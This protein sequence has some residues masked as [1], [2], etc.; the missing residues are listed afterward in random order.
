[1]SSHVSTSEDCVAAIRTVNWEAL[2]L[3][4][5]VVGHII[6]GG[7]IVA[8]VLTAER[9]LWTDLSLVV[10][11]VLSLHTITTLVR[12]IKFD[13]LTSIK[14]LPWLWSLIEVPIKFT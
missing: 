2:A 4:P 3:R 7:L 6:I 10:S 13:K 8:A 9:A 12:T 1:M 11:H 14:L 5:V